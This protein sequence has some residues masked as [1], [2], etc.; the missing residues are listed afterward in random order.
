MSV[1]SNG[2]IGLSN[3]D[4]QLTNEM[5]NGQMECPLDI[6]FCLHRDFA[7]MGHSNVHWTFDWSIGHLTGPLDP[8]D[9]WKPNGQMERPTDISIVFARGENI[10]LYDVLASPIACWSEARVLAIGICLLDPMDPLDA[11]LSIGHLLVHWIQ[12][13]NGMSNEQMECPMDISIL[14]T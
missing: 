2:S 1:G 11:R 8:M 3:I 6:G 12:W 5:P 13:T 14:F 10:I 4:E 7:S 9:K